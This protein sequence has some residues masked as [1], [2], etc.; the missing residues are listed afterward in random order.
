MAM[1]ILILWLLTDYF[2]METVQKDA[3]LLMKAWIRENK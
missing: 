1:A 2:L 3:K